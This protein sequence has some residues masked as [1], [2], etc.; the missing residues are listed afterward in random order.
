MKLKQ[1]AEDF[2]ALGI[3]CYFVGGY[4]RDSLMGIRSD[5]KDICLVGVKDKSVVEKIIGKYGIITPE[6]G[7]NFPNWLAIIDGEKIDFAL[8]RTE[9]LIGNNRKAFECSTE[10]VTIEEDLSRRDLTINAI[11]RNILTDMYIDPFGGMDDILDGIARETSNAFGEDTL[12]VYRTA[13][14]IARFNLRPTP[15]LIRMCKSLKPTDISDERVGMELMKLFTLPADTKVSKFFYFLKDIDWLGYH[16]PELEACIGVPQSPKNHPEGHVFIHTMHCIDAAK[17]WFMRAVML[18]HDLGKA[19]HTTLDGINWSEFKGIRHGAQNPFIGK[20]QSIG[21]EEAG[22]PLCKAMLKRIS[23]TNHDVINRIST[24]VKLHMIRAVY[25]TDNAQKIVRRHLRELMNMEIPY[26]LLVET[27][28]CDLA[29]RPPLDPINPEI[30]QEL[31]KELLESGAMTP[32]VTGKLLQ[33]LGLKDGPE[34]GAITKKALELQDRGTLNS[35]N[36]RERLIQSGFK[37][38]KL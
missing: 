10:D 4:V 14:F 28:R 34:M 21:H 27:V 36:W 7:K 8:A 16:F 11:A 18:C 33:S 30:G 19:T 38:L 37:I 23:F 17:D 29:G 12:R 1:I 3:T 9:K 20:I 13:R 26:E 24:L 22:V 2:S 5:D 15:S 25:T 6:I 35:D 32:I 31:A